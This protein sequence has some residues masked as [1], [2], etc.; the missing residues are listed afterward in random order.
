[1][2]LK[3]GNLIHVLSSFQPHNIIYI[4]LCQYIDHEKRKIN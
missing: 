4:A 2:P 1:M 3:S